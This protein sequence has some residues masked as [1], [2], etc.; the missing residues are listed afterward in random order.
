MERDDGLD[1][2]RLQVQLVMKQLEQRKHEKS[3]EKKGAAKGN[4]KVPQDDLVVQ[5]GTLNNR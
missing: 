5:A 1:N 4:G 3:K 2:F